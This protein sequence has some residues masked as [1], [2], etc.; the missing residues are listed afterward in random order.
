MSS[1]VTS[2]EL[3]WSDDVELA[4]RQ[5]AVD[6]KPV[7]VCFLSPG[8][9]ASGEFE[10][11]TLQSTTVGERVTHFHWVKLDVERN[12]TLVRR[13]RIRSTPR[14]DL[15]DPEG[16]TRVRI[17]GALSPEEFRAELDGFLRDIVNRTVLPTESAIR[18][19][20]GSAFTPVTDIPTG[21]LGLSN[22]YSNVGY[23]PLRLGSQSPY[24]SLR[25]GLTPLS[26]ST[27]AQGRWEVHASETWVNVFSYRPGEALLDYEMLDTRFSIAYG[28][29]DEL[30]ID[31]EFENRS[32][33][34]GVM[35]RFIDAFHRSFG[36][37]DGGRHL[38][39]ND[40]FAVQVFDKNGNPALNLTT[41]DRGSFS[42]SLLLSAQHNITCGTDI[43]PALSYA[44][45][46]RSELSNDRRLAG[47]MYV[48]PQLSLEASKAVGDFCLYASV[49]FA[50][51]G[52]EHLAGIKFHPTQVS[53]LG[54]LEWRFTSSMS[55]LFQYLVT[56]GDVE[57]LGPFSKNSHE[58]TLGWKGEI[59]TRSVLEIG[60][61]ENI[62]NFA[63]SPDFGVH[64]GLAYRF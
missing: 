3:E 51:F 52:T 64:V 26:P 27:L 63:S 25:F 56:Q 24:Q 28:V 53:A 37:T 31:V 13:F 50:Y 2:Q 38:F 10:N 48:E 21:Y 57:S 36:L 46:L 16:K 23:G 39:P 20:R 58:I 8:S 22:C 42:N 49:A 35:D 5:A 59:W 29:L 34:G 33:F 54:A 60:F 1:R 45:T 6:H 19:I 17:S 4:Q 12:I 11:E 43:L 18:E 44:V 7:V 40:R 61:I 55:F 9:T 41:G 62:I 15:I 14:V 32:A 30:Q 47:E